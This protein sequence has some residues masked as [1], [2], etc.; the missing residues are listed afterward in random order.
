M[1]NIKDDLNNS[2]SFPE[3]VLVRFDIINMFPSIDNI[4]GI[5]SVIRFLDHRVCKESPTQQVTEAL[6]LCL[7]VNC[8]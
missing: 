6:E 3:S 8:M 2:N 5:K 1:L 4:M 7:T